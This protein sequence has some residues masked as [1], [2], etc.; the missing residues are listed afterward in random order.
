MKVKAQPKPEPI[1]A[2]Q[3]PDFREL[4]IHVPHIVYD[5]SIESIEERRAKAQKFDNAKMVAA[6]LGCSVDTVFRNRVPKKQI[7]GINGKMYAV[8]K[9]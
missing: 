2:I 8:R 6:F 7:K 1:K 5:L 9:M 3:Q 4:D